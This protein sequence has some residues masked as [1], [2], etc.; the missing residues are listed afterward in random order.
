MKKK[1]LKILT[2][3]RRPPSVQDIRTMFVKNLTKELKKNY[4]NVQIIWLVY[5][6]KRI[7]FDSVNHPEYQVLNF[8]DYENAVEDLLKRE[9]MEEAGIEVS[10]DFHYIN[11]VAFIRPDG[12]SQLTVEYEDGVAKRLENVVISTQHDPDVSMAKL[13]RDIK[14]KVIKPIIPKKFLDKKRKGEKQK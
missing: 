8:H 10:D 12:K 5:Q 9:T 2:T 7:H 6:P 1:S 13:R 3:N 14:E 4:E 11:S